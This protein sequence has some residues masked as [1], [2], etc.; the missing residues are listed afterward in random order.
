MLDD[1][2]FV[3]RVVTFPQSES[4]GTLYTRESSDG[5]WEE[6]ADAR[7]DV[8]LPP[9][10][11]VRLVVSAESAEDLETQTRVTDA[12]LLHLRDLRKLHTLSLKHTG[13]SDRG[14]VAIGGL[15]SLRWL[16]LRSTAVTDLGLD[17]LR[18]LSVL[19]YLCLADTAVTDAGVHLLGRLPSLRFVDLRGTQ[20]TAVGV[21]RLKRLLPNCAA[22]L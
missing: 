9:T 16:A 20:V 11:D 19:E 5:G 21:G 4:V 13:I 15:A 12:G 17:H 2:E 14:M 8:A 10:G 3:F 22:D 18:S 6:F 7:G 1:V